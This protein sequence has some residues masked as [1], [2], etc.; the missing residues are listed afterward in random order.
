MDY[1]S[2]EDLLSTDYDELSEM[3]YECAF[4]INRIL[5]YDNHNIYIED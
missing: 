3:M 2:I 1:E 5:H 4:G